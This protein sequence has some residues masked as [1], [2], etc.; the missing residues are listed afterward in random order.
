MQPKF[1][2][3]FNTRL[4]YKGFDLSIIGIFKSGGLLIATPYG[5]NGY[6]ITQFLS[7]GINDRKD[8]YGG[9]LQ[10]RARFLLDI[11]DAIRAKVGRDFHLQV[12]ISAIDYNNVIPWEGRGNT[13][14]DSIQVCKWVQ[15][16]QADALHISIGS[17]FPHPLNP[18]G[19]FAFDTIA[20]T[21]DAMLS[22]GVHTLRNYALFRYSLL[23]PLFYWI[24]F[25]M[26]KGKPVAL[27]KRRATSGCL[28]TQPDPHSKNWRHTPMATSFSRGRPRTAAPLR[29]AS[30]K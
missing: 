19:G 11:I 28:L 1:Q 29:S 8:E 5:A 9:S 6:L 20:R 23:R 17:L 7:S 12:K 25:R 16:H 14:E 10:N 30:W 2:G 15:E 3:G 24:W 4:A 26:K 27:T 21:Y 22:S 13:L 18:P